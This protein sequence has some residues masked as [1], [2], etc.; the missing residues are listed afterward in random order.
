MLKIIAMGQKLSPSNLLYRFLPKNKIIKG[1]D[2]WNMIP[3]VKPSKS[4]PAAMH[5]A[6]IKIN[7]KILYPLY[8]L[9]KKI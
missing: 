3:P 6:E 1:L 9:V 4:I 2:V 7:V 5:P 8:L